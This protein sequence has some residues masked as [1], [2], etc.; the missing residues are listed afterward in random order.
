MTSPKRLL[1][2]EQPA[3]SPPLGEPAFL[4]I[5]RLR[6]PFGLQG[7]MLME[8]LTDFPERL[9]VGMTVYV[10][11]HYLPV[12]I[13][14]IRG[15]MKAL[16][17]SLDEYNDREKA[18]ELRNQVVTIPRSSIPPLPDGE[19]YHHQVIGLHVIDE[20][21]RPLGQVTDILETGANDV[22]IVHAENGRELLIP[23]IDAVVLDIDLKSSTIKIHPL[24][25][26]IPE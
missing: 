17:V 13:I 23:V 14:G 24:P 5:G 18:G 22:L 25:G 2:S 1:S 10:G 15:H 11:D 8:V 9:Q 21:N 12:K 7:E 19:F 16:L 20:T 4:V 6:R 3:G 26:L